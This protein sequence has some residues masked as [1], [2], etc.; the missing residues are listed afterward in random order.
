VGAGRSAQASTQ[1]H[2]QIIE[3]VGHRE[4][5]DRVGVRA[6]TEGRREGLA[7]SSSTTSTTVTPTPSSSLAKRCPEHVQP[8]T[9]TP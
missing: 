4:R 8:H 5:S 1:M 2:T 7:A 3:S 6:G 9:L